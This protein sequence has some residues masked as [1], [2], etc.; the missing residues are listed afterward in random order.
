MWNRVS[1]WGG[2][3]LK[4]KRFSLQVR[5]IHTTKP[6]RKTKRKRG[7]PCHTPPY[8]QVVWRQTEGKELNIG[9]HRNVRGSGWLQGRD[10]CVR[11][12]SQLHQHPQFSGL[13]QSAEYRSQRFDLKQSRVNNKLECLSSR[14]WIL[15]LP[16]LHPIVTLERDL[17]ERGSNYFFYYYFCCHTLSTSKN[18]SLSLLWNGSMGLKG[19]INVFVEIVVLK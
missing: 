15:L 9:C 14:V 10:P 12:W 4:Q 8:G 19:S 16:Y 17:T 5:E 3:R 18:H 2:T 6:T 13:K 1:V 11:H 7:E